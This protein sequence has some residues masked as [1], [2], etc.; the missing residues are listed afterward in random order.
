MRGKTVFF[1]PGTFSKPAYLLGAKPPLL[2]FCDP[3]STYLSARS[4]YIDP[5]PIRGTQ[6]D[7][8]TK[9]NEQ[10]RF[11]LSLRSNQKTSGSERFLIRLSIESGGRFF[12]LRFS[13]SDFLA[14]ARAGEPRPEPRTAPHIYRLP[15]PALPRFLQSIRKEAENI[16]SRRLH[17]LLE[18]KIARQNLY[19]CFQGPFPILHI[20]LERNPSLLNF[21]DPF[22]HV[23]ES[24]FEMEM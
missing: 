19:S 17:L 22:S 23:T 15:T 10:N 20:S 4:P 7:R 2:N 24:I 8:E 6:S 16:S 12:L 18:R 5:A 14:L 1:L 13:A 11:R 21:F 3:F 9:I